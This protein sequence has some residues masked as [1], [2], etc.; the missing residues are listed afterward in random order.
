MDQT[1]AAAAASVG[2]VWG[3]H[4]ACPVG[5]SVSA[6]EESEPASVPFPAAGLRKR[7]F[8]VEAVCSESAAKPVVEPDS[9]AASRSV[10]AAC[11]ASGPPGKRLGPQTGPGL[12]SEEQAETGLK[13][14]EF[15]MF[16]PVGS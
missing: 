10:W 13:C 12:A 7:P 6:A 9:A 5:E 2:L 15:Y 4:S 1:A 16:H 8:G 11:P 14:F 3:T